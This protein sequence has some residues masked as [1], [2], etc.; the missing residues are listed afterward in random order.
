MGQI[1]LE[2]RVR[3]PPFEPGRFEPSELPIATQ[4]TTVVRD[5]S[6]KE[7]VESMEKITPSFCLGNEK[8]WLI[9]Q[10]LSLI[11]I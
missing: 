5:V 4:T 1:K 7:I 11:H 6:P 9:E 8:S 10:R 2:Q 3:Y